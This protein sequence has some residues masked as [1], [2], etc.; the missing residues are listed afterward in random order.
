VLGLLSKLLLVRQLVWSLLVV[1]QKRPHS[2]VS[3]L[4]YVVQ[5]SL[6]TLLLRQLPGLLRV[7]VVIEMQLGCLRNFANRS[8][9]PS[10]GNF[11]PSGGR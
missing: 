1:V 2:L 3:L 4:R 9:R 11:L 6:R 8:K 10:S 5:V 7:L